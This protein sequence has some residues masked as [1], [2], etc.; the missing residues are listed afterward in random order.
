MKTYYSDRGYVLVYHMEPRDKPVLTV[1]Q[2]CKWYTPYLV[3]MDG[4]VRAADIHN[5]ELYVNDGSAWGGS[6]HVWNPDAIAALAD[7][8]VWYVCD[9]SFEMII[10]RWMR[11]YMEQFK[12]PEFLL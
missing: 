7:E 4:S 12:S 2:Y 3:M 10:G 9:A 5:L 8:E 11:E 1:E 6:T